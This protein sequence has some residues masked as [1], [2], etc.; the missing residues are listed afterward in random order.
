MG[1]EDSGRE[2]CPSTYLLV[3]SSKQESFMQIIWGLLES[4][5]VAVEGKL[6]GFVKFPADC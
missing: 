5:V 3:R 1:T 4:H 6:G 2:H